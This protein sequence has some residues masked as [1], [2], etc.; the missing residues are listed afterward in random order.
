MTRENEI[1]QYLHYNPGASRSEIETGMNLK[2]SPATVKRI[3]AGLVESGQ[4]VVIGQGRATRYSVSAQAHVT[5]PLNIDTYFEKETDERIVQTDFNFELINDILP[6]VE[7]FT[8]QEKEQL[9]ALQAQFTNNIKDITPT[10]YRKEMERLG[11]DL[12]WKSSQIE[13]NTY[14]LLETEKLL[15][16]KQTAQGKTK[17]EAVMLLNHKDALDYILEEPEHLKELTIRRIEEL[18]TLLVKEL[19]VDKGIRRRRV[20]VTGTN[21]RPLDNEFQIREALEDSC[22][23]INGKESVFEKALLALVLISYIQAFSDGNK[24]TARMTSNAILIANRY[25]P[26]SFRTVDSVDYKK[27]M[28]IFYEQNNISAFKKIFIDQFAF[29]VGTYF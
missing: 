15:K 9:D 24:R 20:G 25:C 13:G 6:K 26:I 28:L 19:D 22:R 11:I 8:P 2:E 14:S 1:L 5:M 18:H 21:Y 4:A 29:A 23:L 7:L 12:S 10:E 3:L 17:E 16:E 27:A